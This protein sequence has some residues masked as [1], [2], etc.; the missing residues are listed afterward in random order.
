[1]NNDIKKR[2]KQGKDLLKVQCSEGNYDANEYI[3]IHC[4]NTVKKMYVDW[5]LLRNFVDPSP[6]VKAWGTEQVQL[7]PEVIDPSP[8]LGD[9]NVSLNPRLSVY[10]DDH[11][12]DLLVFS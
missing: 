11:D 6:S 2:I 9:V 1:M 7:Y 8:I 3:V 4:C 12:D 5:I 10:V